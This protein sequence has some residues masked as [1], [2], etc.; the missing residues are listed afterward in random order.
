MWRVLERTAGV[1]EREE[2]YDFPSSVEWIDEAY[3][4]NGAIAPE[5]DRFAM[6]VRADWIRGQARRFDDDGAG[7]DELV[8]RDITNYRVPVYARAYR[9]G[10]SDR[11]RD[12][13]DIWMDE[14]GSP[15][16]EFGDDLQGVL[17][18]FSNRYAVDIPVW[19]L[20]DESLEQLWYFPNSDGLPV[21]NV[22]YSYE[23]GIMRS[24]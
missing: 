18:A 20:S 24:S 9:T 21:V 15:V 4:V 5:S 19:W 1:L 22:T 3:D 6:A 8:I 16:E 12:V 7:Q 17:W 10:G 11:D 14:Y 23:A 13:R 2:V